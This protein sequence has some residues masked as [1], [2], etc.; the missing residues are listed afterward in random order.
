MI[1]FPTFPHLPDTGD[2]LP[3]QTH[4][5]VGEFIHCW[6]SVEYDLSRTFSAT[7]G[8]P[9]GRL[10]PFYGE[11]GRI[12]K[13]RMKLLK[14]AIDHEFVVRPHQEREAQFDSLVEA[15]SWYSDRRNEIAHS[16]VYDLMALPRFSKRQEGRP[17]RPHYFAMPPLYAFTKLESYRQAKHSPPYALSSVEIHV[18]CQWCLELLHECRRFRHATFPTE[19][20]DEQR[21]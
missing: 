16:V 15:T 8:R 10:I 21:T 20:P 17:L 12:F 9:D 11:N 1:P 3:G 6:E 19:W 2:Q 14:I 18:L 4:E 5:A 13:E 7:M